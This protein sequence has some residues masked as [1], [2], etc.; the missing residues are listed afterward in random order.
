[1]LFTR[2]YKATASKIKSDTCI[3]IDE[4]QIFKNFSTKDVIA[5]KTR[6][7]LDMINNKIRRINTVNERLARMKADVV[8]KHN[9]IY[10]AVTELQN[11]I[12]SDDAWLT[13]VE[14]DKIDVI[15][16]E[17]FNIVWEML[18]E[19][20]KRISLEKIT[21]DKHKDIEGYV[22]ELTD[23]IN[24][25]IEHVTRMCNEIDHIMNMI[26][27]ETKFIDKKIR[28]TCKMDNDTLDWIDDKLNGI[29]TRSRKKK[30]IN[31]SLA[32]LIH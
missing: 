6:T 5:T 25:K 3:D 11:E 32:D 31:T 9:L 13:S 28:K 15:I 4:L 20:K 26:N 19:N 10:E 2:E 14:L 29:M 18:Y 1:M 30:K 8:K 23:L 21:V 22:N 12:Y 7:M 17:A 27:N 24:Y 16:E